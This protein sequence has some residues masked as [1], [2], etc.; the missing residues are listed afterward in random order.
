MS[1]ST[2]SRIAELI[3]VNQKDMLE[4]WLGLQK[5]ASTARID[6]LSDADLRREAAEC[7]L[8]DRSLAISWRHCCSL[9]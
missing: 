1:H 6:L 3:A 5:A 2:S 7:P 4:E 8:R 9:S